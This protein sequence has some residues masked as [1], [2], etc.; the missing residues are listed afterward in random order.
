MYHANDSLFRKEYL[1]VP[2]FVESTT[3]LPGKVRYEKKNIEY[4]DV[5]Y[6]LKVR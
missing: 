3:R 6:V 4:N 5:R 2:F 1:Q